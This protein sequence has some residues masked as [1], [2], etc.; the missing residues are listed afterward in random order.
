[1]IMDIGKVTERTKGSTNQQFAEFA[2]A[3]C[4]LN[5]SPFDTNNGNCIP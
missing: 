2:G 3:Q 4:S 5:S 1:M